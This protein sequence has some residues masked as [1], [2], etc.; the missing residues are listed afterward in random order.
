[1]VEAKAGLQERGGTPEW[2]EIAVRRGVGGVRY[3]ERGISLPYGEVERGA[4]GEGIPPNGAP[5]HTTPGTGQGSRNGGRS[6]ATEVTAPR[7][8]RAADAVRPAVTKEGTPTRT[9]Q[10]VVNDYTRSADGRGGGGAPGGS[11]WGKS[12][13]PARKAHR[14][15]QGRRGARNS[16][17]GGGG[18]P[19]DTTQQGLVRARMGA[20]PS[21]E[22]GVDLPGLTPVRGHLPL[23]EVY[24]DF[25]RHNDGMH[26]AGRV[27]DDSVWQS[28]WRWLAAQSAS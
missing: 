6:T 27:P 26:L 4:R 15:T 17:G 12:R 24:G 28:R 2:A 11:R 16:R 20:A 14:T 22:E 13:N 3:N 5:S 10:C 21:T 19:T 23:Q 1:M 18:S 7:R 25:H 8:P 9:V